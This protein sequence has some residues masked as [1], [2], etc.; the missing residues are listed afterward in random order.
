MNFVYSEIENS[1]LDK[2]DISHAENL[3]EMFEGMKINPLPD[4][5]IENRIIED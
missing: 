2:F 1:N 5:T 3:S 4:Y